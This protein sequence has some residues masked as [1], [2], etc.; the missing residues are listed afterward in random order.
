M[1]DLDKLILDD[2]DTCI[3]DNRYRI[4][5]IIESKNES[6]PN[7]EDFLEAYRNG[8][9]ETQHKVCLAFA[10]NLQIPYYVQY[11]SGSTLSVK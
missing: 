9:Y 2:L 10:D 6:F 1:Q 3:H 4:S 11:K 8:R 7:F 5:G